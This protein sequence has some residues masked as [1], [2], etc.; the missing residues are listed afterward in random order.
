MLVSVTVTQLGTYPH[1]PPLPARTRKVKCLQV[2]QISSFLG[3]HNLSKLGEQKAQ[4][5][6]ITDTSI[7]MRI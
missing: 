2:S 7:D 3:R 5:K 4:T 6:K 1:T